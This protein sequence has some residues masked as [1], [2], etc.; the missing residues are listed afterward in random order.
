MK[1]ALFGLIALAV[2]TAACHEERRDPSPD[3][4]AVRVRS[5]GAHQDLQQQRPPQNG[6]A[7]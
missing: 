6:E 4:G 1:K 2:L 7:R 5:E 3:Y